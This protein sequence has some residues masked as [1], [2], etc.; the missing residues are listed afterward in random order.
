MTKLE[1]LL[2]AADAACAVLDDARAAACAAVAFDGYD[3]FGAACA[4]E[5][6]AEAVYDDAYTARD[7]ARDAYEAELKKQ[8]ENSND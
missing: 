4:A 2:A 1:E 7:A 6:T 8:E 3:S 5:A